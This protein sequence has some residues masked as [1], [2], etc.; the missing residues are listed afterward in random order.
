MKKRRSAQSAMQRQ[1]VSLALL[2]LATKELVTGVKSE[3]TRNARYLTSE[4][5]ELP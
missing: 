4:E 5:S 3:I 1:Q 2:A